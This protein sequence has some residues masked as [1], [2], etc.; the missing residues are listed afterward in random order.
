MNNNSRT[1]NTVRNSITGISVQMII[2]LTSFVTRTIFIRTL[3]IDYLG[4]NGLFTNILSI[5]SL[6]EL[7]FGGAM[8]Y[9]LYKPMAEKNNNKINGLMN[10]YSRIYKIIGTVIFILGLALMPFLPLIIK[11]APNVDNLYFIYFL[12]L[13]NSASS[14]FFAY[15]RSI[16]Q[17]DQNNYIISQ[18][19]FWVVILKSIIQSL[20]LILFQNYFLYLII[21]IVFT[22]IENILI[23]K[24]VD[25]LYPFLEKHNINNLDKKTRNEIS[26]NVKALSVYKLGSTLMDS[27][28]DIIISSI[29]GITEIGLLSNYNLI[30]NTVSMALNQINTSLAGSVGNY[31]ST[32]N[33]N[34]QEDLLYRLSFIYYIFYG[35]SSMLL[36]MLLNPFIN[37]WIGIDYILPQTTVALLCFNWYFIGMLNPVWTFR[38]TKGLFVYGRFRPFVTGLINIIVSIVLG[39]E[40]GLNGVLLGTTISRV[41]TNSWFDPYIIFKKGF[42]KSPNKY[43]LTQVMFVLLLLIPVGISIYLFK[44]LPKATIPIFITQII[45]VFIIG[46]LFYLVMAL[47][48]DNFKYL[49]NILKKFNRPKFNRG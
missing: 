10:F 39:R 35:L 48:T 28:D 6:A 15:K 16:L 42:N 1:S 45:I 37:L 49:I 29:I 40:F 9:S 44:L 11:D 23:S 3:S 47:I 41:A 7:G 5:L 31:V 20:I 33:T 34:R 25:S 17:A 21:Q 24:K 46:I 19:H 30:I 32:E 14:Y 26:E 8:V 18:Y 36:Y 43:I 12:F 27:T 4:V 2:A 13:L 22:L 38:S